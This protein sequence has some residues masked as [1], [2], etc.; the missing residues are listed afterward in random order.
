MLFRCIECFEPIHIIKETKQFSCPNCG[1]L[2]KSVYDVPLLV[3]DYSDY[4]SKKVL[5]CENSIRE[6]ERDL[7]AETAGSDKYN[8]INESLLFQINT[9]KTLQ[10]ELL[11]DCAP[12]DLVRNI[13]KSQELGYGITFEYLIR[14]WS[15]LPEC[16][17]EIAAIKDAIF[18][19]I[20][21]RKKRALVLGAGL[22]RIA[23]EM[24][25]KFDEIYAVDLA[26][27]MPFLLRKL[28]LEQ[29]VVFKY[30]LKKNVPDR[31]SLFLD[32]KINSGAV[33]KK[34]F[35][36]GDSNFHYLVADAA[37]LPFVDSGFDTIISCYFTDVVPLDGIID[38]LSRVLKPGGNFI[39]FGP[40]DFHFSDLSK[41]L[42]LSEIYKVFTNA[43]FKVSAS[44]PVL[45][46]HVALPY[47]FNRKFYLNQLFSAVKQPKRL[48]KSLC[49]KDILKLTRPI[50]FSI[51]GILT[52]D[53]EMEYHNA[54]FKTGNQK[55]YEGAMGVFE[56]LK[57][58]D[59]KKEL[60]EIFKE[61]S[62][63]YDLDKATQQKILL[64]LSNLVKD[65]TLYQIS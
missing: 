4:V 7:I 43:N 57:R 47:R 20:G 10:A 65:E 52:Q 62:L 24:F 56:V 37:N 5:F 45:L 9:I 1:H 51:S 12:A 46:E 22:G 34:L 41:Q 25:D 18:S 11:K 16:E 40:L 23:I 39:H 42:T 19:K 15:L 64:I 38:E 49:K 21:K 27:E 50:S 13:G 63:N 55:A 8:A 32:L 48:A 14:D 2:V 58:L 3:S 28:I 6:L 26:L 36:A 33:Q 29:D 53:G 17:Q 60:A 59:G 54:E 35:T 44:Q 61:L 31:E 30:F